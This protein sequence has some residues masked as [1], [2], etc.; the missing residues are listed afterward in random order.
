MVDMWRL[1]F[2]RSQWVDASRCVPTSHSRRR[3]CS[4]RQPPSCY[5]LRSEPTRA[6][7]EG[8]LLQEAKDAVRSQRAG[9]VHVVCS[10]SPFGR[11]TGITHTGLELNMSIFGRNRG[12]DV[13]AAF[14]A[15]ADGNRG[16]PVHGSFGP[17]AA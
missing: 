7:F 3:R 17:I 1:G 2:C 15:L 13:A 5:P 10:S 4:R 6:A 11:V 8:E 16:V 9:A 12:I 14:T